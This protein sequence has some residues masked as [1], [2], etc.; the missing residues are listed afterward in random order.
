MCSNV[1]NGRRG[2]DN[3]NGDI[4]EVLTVYYNE[5]SDTQLQSTLFYCHQFLTVITCLVW[6]YENI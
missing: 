2:N 5:I 4:L 6:L 3:I 1:I